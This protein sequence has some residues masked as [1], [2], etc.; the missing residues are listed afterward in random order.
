MSIASEI[1]AL[2]TNLTAAKNAVTSKGGSVGDTGL[3]GLATEIASIPVG[4]GGDE[5]AGEGTITGYNTATGEITGYGF[6]STAGS[7]Y[8]LDR[9]THTYVLQPH[10]TWSPTSITLTNPVDLSTIEGTTSLVAILNDGTWSTKQ[11]IT[12][13]NAVSGYAKA[14]VKDFDTGNVKVVQISSADWSQFAVRNNGYAIQIVCGNETFYS[15][16]VVGVQFG[17]DFDLDTLGA[18][19]LAYFVNLNQPL[20]I[21]EGVVTINTNF[22]SYCFNFNQPLSLP[23]TLIN[24]SSGN[25]MYYCYSFN[26]P[27]TIPNSVTDIGSYFMSYCYSFNQKL[28]LPTSI[29]QIKANFF[30]YNSSFNKPLIIPEGVT[31][32]ANEFLSY[33]YK[34]DQTVTL[35]STLTSIGQ[36]FMY[37][38]WAFN[39]PLV[40]PNT[41]T[42]IGSGFLNRNWSFD[43][44]I[45]FPTSLTTIGGGFMSECSSFNK[46]LVLPASLTNIGD[47]FLFYCYSFAQP[48]TIPSS[49]TT[50]GTAFMQNCYSF[51]HITVNN[52]VSPNDNSTLGV[53]YNYVKAYVKGRTIDGGGASVWTS[54][55]PIRTS[56]PYRKFN[57]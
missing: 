40:L 14:Y 49:V 5:P 9:E 19:T 12:G 16:E 42:T 36:S 38:C 10:S 41:I 11:L 54:N 46:P 29:T 21:P 35:P 57:I 28:T 2:N 18:R 55:L 56:N 15:D 6:G 37:N 25:F 39:Q 44:T 45:T 4:G 7:V 23:S 32:I 50:I 20:V 17:T 34:F 31:S 53:N 26:Q 8:L 27:L 3:A 51:S 24:L 48:L 33:N 30:G 22:L 47:S 1:T 43:N 52:A 13:Q